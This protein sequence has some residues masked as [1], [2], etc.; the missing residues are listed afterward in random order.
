MK[1]VAL[2]GAGKIGEAITALLAHS[3]RYKV[4]IA[5]IDAQRAERVASQQ[6]NGQ[7]V[8]ATLDLN[9][10]QKTVNLLKGVDA[11]ISALPFHQN[12]NVASLAREC[13][14]HYFDLTEDRATTAAVRSI[15]QGAQ[16]V[17]MPQCGLAPG[18]ISVAAL[19]LVKKFERVISVNMRVGA[20]PVYPSNRL[21]YNLT[22]STEG[23]INEYL[24]PCDAISGGKRIVVHP[25]EGYEI[26]TIDN[27][28]YEAFNTSGGIGSLAE[29][30][31][32]TVEDISYKTL[33]YVGHNELIKFLF[34]DLGFRDRPEE[35]K[36]IFERALPRTLQ[37]KCIVYVE[38]VG[39]KDGVLTQEVFSRTVYSTSIGVS[40][41]GA[42]QLTTAAGVLVPLDWVLNG[43]GRNR[44]GFVGIEEISLNE[45]LTNEFGALGY[46]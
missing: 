32:G 15:A 43:E 42:I 30:L 34:D 1:H 29:K 3:G 41:F 45:F 24:H 4:T 5:D 13:D 40:L 8:G 22:W 7:C 31:I 37:D 36:D 23:L 25:L 39:I 17:F 21:K 12:E 38:V 9:N 44:S 18:F 33:R 16:R 14:I 11:V 26:L 10:I 2:F 19:D 27:T 46:Q 20:L 28:E 35:L 6:G